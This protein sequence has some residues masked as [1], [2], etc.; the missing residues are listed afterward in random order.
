MGLLWG[1]NDPIY[2][3]TILILSLLM[4]SLSPDFPFLP[5]FP[6]GKTEC[7]HKWDAQYF[8]TPT[9]APPPTHTS[10]PGQHKPKNKW[11]S[12]MKT[13]LSGLERIA[14]DLLS[15]QRSTYWLNITYKGRLSK[16]YCSFTTFTACLLEERFTERIVKE[17]EFFQ[18]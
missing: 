8:A 2:L 1:L 7:F 9:L 4:F 17:Y 14:K 16:H 5:S 18:N 12:H 3:K 10:I 15:E 11:K 6:W 13:R